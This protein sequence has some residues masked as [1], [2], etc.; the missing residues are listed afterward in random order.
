M[1][2]THKQRHLLLTGSTKITC[3]RIGDKNT[4]IPKR[5]NFRNYLR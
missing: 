2:I 1:K 4:L 5:S 3:Q